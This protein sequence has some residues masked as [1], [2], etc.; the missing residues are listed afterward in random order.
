MYNNFKIVNKMDLRNYF[1]EAQEEVNDEFFNYDGDD[2]DVGVNTTSYDG[3][4]QCE[5]GYASVWEF[6]GMSYFFTER[7]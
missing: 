3:V 6:C 2:Y 4:A 5:P 7:L 1:I